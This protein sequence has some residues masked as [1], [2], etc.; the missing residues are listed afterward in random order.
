M[1]ET[2]DWISRAKDGAYARFLLGGKDLLGVDVMIESVKVKD[3][4]HDNDGQLI[5]STL[6]IAFV[7]GRAKPVKAARGGKKKKK[8]K[9]TYGIADLRRAEIAAGT[10]Y[11]TPKTNR[12]NTAVY[13]KD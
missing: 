8:P 10:Y 7:A 12:T 4:S 11:S 6:Q 3:V 2:K 9:K 13:S 5:K 1:A